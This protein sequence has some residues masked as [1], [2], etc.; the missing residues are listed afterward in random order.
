MEQPWM[1]PRCECLDPTNIN[2]MHVTWDESLAPARL[3]NPRAWLVKLQIPSFRMGSRAL[4][5]NKSV[6]SV[7]LCLAQQQPFGG[8]MLCSTLKSHNFR[9]ALLIKKVC[10][11]IPLK[12]LI[13][14]TFTCVCCMSSLLSFEL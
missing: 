4:R 10:W 1:L 2:I 6:C 11:S 5:I 3:S 7:S 13:Y 9:G 12:G 14:A 8:T